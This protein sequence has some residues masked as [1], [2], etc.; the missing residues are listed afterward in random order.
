M[1]CRAGR[2]GKEM[3]VSGIPAD[4]STLAPDV[5][6]YHCPLPESHRGPKFE[7]AVSKVER[8]FSAIETTC[9]LATWRQCPET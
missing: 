2:R 9:Q 3:L 7:P 4:A 5:C 6:A 1:F 8:A